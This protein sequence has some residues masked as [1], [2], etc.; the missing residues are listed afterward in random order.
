[1]K[2]LKN[3]QPG[4][5]FFAALITYLLTSFVILIVAIG[6]GIIIGFLMAKS[7]AEEIS[8]DKFFHNAVINSILFTVISLIYIYP[9][10]I[11]RKHFRS[12]SNPYFLLKRTAYRW[13][14]LL[15]ILFS[16]V[17]IPVFVYSYTLEAAIFGSDKYQG[18]FT[19]IINI[20]TN[21][22]SVSIGLLDT[23]TTTEFILYT[24]TLVLLTSVGEELI[25]RGII[26][27]TLV[28][29]MKN[30]HLAVI[31]TSLLF[32]IFNFTSMNIVLL[33]LLAIFLGYLFIWSGSIWLPVLA[34]TSIFLFYSL[35]RVY[36]TQII[37]EMQIFNIGTKLSDLK[38]VVLFAIGVG[39][40]V[41]L[42]Y[43][44]E[45]KYQQKKR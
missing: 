20:R 22:E 4:Q 25:F 17:A 43:F 24:L 32:T 6:L 1:M 45:K 29:W 21:A 15:I 12:P 31:S 7:G 35:S 11:L 19:F 23:A 28:E 9:A 26:L 14:Y 42:I 13:N 2:I 18:I 38:Y 30:K 37:K 36:D 16:Y 27:N 39:I 3:L 41:Y 10:F 33:F 40:I 8:T 44:L 34:R 5:K